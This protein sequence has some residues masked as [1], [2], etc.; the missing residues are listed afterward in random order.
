MSNKVLTRDQFKQKLIAA[1]ITL[2]QWSI[3]NGFSY[4]MAIRVLNG[5]SKATFGKSHDCAVA[6]GIKADP[7]LNEAA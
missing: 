4:E 7:S 5:Q 6:M 3:K 2:K 1:G